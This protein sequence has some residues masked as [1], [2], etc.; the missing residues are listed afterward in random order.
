[1]RRKLIR[2]SVT[3]NPTV[4]WIAYQVS[5]AFRWNEAPQ[6]LSRDRDRSFGPAYT[7]RIRAMGIRGHLHRA[8]LAG[9]ERLRRATH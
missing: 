9:A 7:H 5:E 1:L 2:V 4:E 6:R 8:P 3:T